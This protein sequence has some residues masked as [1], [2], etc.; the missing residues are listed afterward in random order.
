MGPLTT[1]LA[2]ALLAIGV[3]TTLAW[4]GTTNAAS[5][6]AADGWN[7]IIAAAA[8]FSM[9]TVNLLLRWLRWGFLLRRHH[10][11]MPT[12][13]TFRLFFMTL[14]AALTPLYLGELV[15][16][17][18]VHRNTG[19][20][21]GAVFWTWVIER[22]CDAGAL[23]LFWGLASGHWGL[24]LLGAGLSLGTPWWLAT[25]MNRDPEARRLHTGQVARMWIVAVTFV[26][27]VLAWALPAV[28]AWVV[29]RVIAGP[30]APV[31]A[32]TAFVKGTLLGAISGVPGGT[33]VTGSAI[34]LSLL[35]AGVDASRATAAVAIFRLGTV[36]Y[37]V[38]LGVLL[39]VVWRRDLVR[40][41]RPGQTQVHFDALADQYGEE[42][43]E[44]VRQR[45]LARKVQAMLRELGEP[46]PNHVIQ[47]LDLGCGQGW[48]AAELA[49]AGYT[50]SGVD[51]SEGQLRNA[52]QYCARV[53]AKVDLRQGDGGK[54]PFPDHTFDFAYSINVL[55]HVTT[56]EG[57]ME[58]FRELVRVLKPGGVFFLHEMNIE[59]PMFRFYMSY[60]FPLLKSIDEGTELWLRPTRL[61]PVEHARWSDERSYFTFLPDFLP[62]IVQR[63]LAP[64]ERRLEASRL[65]GYSAHYMVALR[66]D[67]L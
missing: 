9:T 14:P 48:Y 23:L 42:L 60:L 11:R 1:F 2:G 63:G 13:D 8:T 67:P 17:A 29:V 37:A 30:V 64:L 33:A 22:S 59:N 40:L 26:L 20:R 21:G 10:V 58:V 32:V 4:V 54:L 16:V 53:G 61:P 5:V 56:P 31:V 18:V 3:G 6:L 57:Q 36:W 47:G 19:K 39:L 34:I 27:T 52:S 46:G 24:L 49:L 25:V 7:V 35:E 15:R 62:G 45:L 55:H 65:R 12:R 38:A 66:R 43:S 50:M 44:H 41:L 28:S 51:M